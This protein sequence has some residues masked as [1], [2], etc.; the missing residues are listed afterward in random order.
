M[1]TIFFS[2]KKDSLYS[3]AIWGTIA[4]LFFSIILNFSLSIFNIIWILIGVITIGFLIWVW[5]GTGYRIE[6]EVIKIQNGPFKW[7]VSIQD[8]NSISKRKSILA[9]PALS[10][11]RLVLHYGRY[12]EMQLSP[13]AKSEFI[14][15]LLT[16]N[17]QIK[18]DD[19]L[20]NP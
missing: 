11:E 13:K 9:T 20:S 12:G 2:S 18:L 17:P 10:V 8:I 14:E 3:L 6:N 16:K 4:I 15:L 5:F 7:K 1:S 19:T